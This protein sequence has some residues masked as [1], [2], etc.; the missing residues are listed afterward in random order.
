MHRLTQ[1]LGLI[2]GVPLRFRLKTPV[3][4]Q[5]LA[6]DAIARRTSGS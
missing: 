4:A 3:S 2:S 1:G 5:V 6:L